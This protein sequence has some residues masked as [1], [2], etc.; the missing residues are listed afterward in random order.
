MIAGSVADN[1][2]LSRAIDAQNVV[3]KTR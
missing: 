2:V 3:W 1:P